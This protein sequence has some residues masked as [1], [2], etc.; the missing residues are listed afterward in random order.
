MPCLFNGESDID[1]TD[2]CERLREI[3][4]RLARPGVHLF[5]KQANVIA[6]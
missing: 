4:Q 2:V 6:K 5:S 1:Q 3:S